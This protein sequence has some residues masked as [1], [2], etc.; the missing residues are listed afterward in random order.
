[1]AKFKP[2]T[3]FHHYNNINNTGVKPW[4]KDR[5]IPVD[6]LSVNY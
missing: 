6:K 1:M 4:S 3:K 5:N 2:M